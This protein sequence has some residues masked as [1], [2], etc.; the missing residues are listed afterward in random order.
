M[1]KVKEKFLCITSGLHYSL[2][3][4]DQP[5]RILVSLLPSPSRLH[6]GDELK[7]SFSGRIL[8]H[9]T[10]KTVNLQGKL[11]AQLNGALR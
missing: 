1:R 9:T 3:Q 2:E 6:H 4:Y 10:G 7:L 11:A 5:I 8:F